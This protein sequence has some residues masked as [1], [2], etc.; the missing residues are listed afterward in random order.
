MPL[1]KTSKA[2]TLCLLTASILG[3]SLIP[4]GKAYASPPD[5]IQGQVTEVKTAQTSDEKIAEWGNW[6]KDHAYRL[7]TIQPAGTN[8]GTTPFKDLAMLKP[9]LHDKRFVFLGE[10]SHGVAEFNLAK[11]RLIQFLHQEMGYHVLAFE[12]G[13]GNTSLAYGKAGQQSAEQTMKDSIFGVWWSKEIMPLFEY[14]KT[15][16]KSEQPLVLTGFDIQL[17]NP[18]F[19]GAW[20]KDKVMAGRLAEAE[21]KLSGY[22]AGTD[23]AAYRQEKK[24]LIQVYKDALKSLKTEANE[25]HLK[26][27]YPDN[28]KLTTLLERSLNDR[29]RV[30]EEYVEISIESTLGMESGDYTPFLKSMEWRDQA[31]LDNLMW[32]ATEVYPTEKFI[33]WGH[34]DHIRKAQTEVMGSPYPVALMGEQLSDEMKKYSYVLGL[35]PASG[36]T[37]DNMGNV[38]DVLPAEPGSMESILSASG[39]PYTFIDLRYRNHEAGNSWMFEPRFAYSWGMIPESFVPRD[40]YDGIL[41]IDNVKPPEYIRS[42]ASSKSSAPAED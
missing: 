36:Q 34:N 26:L 33:V 10:S 14:I 12:S 5:A 3:T 30:A 20:L 23:L 31:M 28:P 24:Q 42:S 38:H 21:Q 6:A 29:I 2:F 9:L 15:S 22:S 19:D 37:A 35:Y 27:L 17:Q 1:H 32:L 4:D 25:A 41:L 18:L 8:N 13:L 40:Q 16:R 11:T 39:A 7:D